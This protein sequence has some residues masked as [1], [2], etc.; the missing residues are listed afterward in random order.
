MSHV[1]DN[2]ILDLLMNFG[3]IILFFALFIIVYFR[4]KKVNATLIEKLE[5]DISGALEQRGITHEM[6]KI[7]PTEYEF[8]CNVRGKAISVLTLNLKLVD[9][10]SIVSWLINLIFK[11]K[12]KLF[13]GAKFGGDV[14]D[15]DPVYRFDLVP[16]SNKNY[17]QR[18]FDYYVELDDIPTLDKEVDKTFMIKSQSASYVRHLVE[19]EELVELIKKYAENIDSM[20]MQS[21]KEKTDPHFSVTF[22]FNGKEKAPIIDFLRIFFLITNLHRTNHA[23]IKK[24]VAKGSKGKYATGRGSARR[25]SR[26][27][28]KKNQR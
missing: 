23:S 24:L 17:I 27:K 6:T 8:R 11:D 18:R 25:G 19:N 9:R 5:R 16:Y 14:G 21:S 22:T 15:E 20:G 12:E 4:G 1:A 10:A 7:P 3:P 2:L 28:S 13:I 26:K